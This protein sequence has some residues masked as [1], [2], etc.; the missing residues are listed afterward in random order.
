MKFTTLFSH[1]ALASL[2]TGCCT[3]GGSYMDI[4]GDAD[5]NTGVITLPV[6]LH[7]TEGQFHLV[8]SMGCSQFEWAKPETIAKVEVPLDFCKDAKLAP[9]G[10]PGRSVN[11]SFKFDIAGKNE[12]FSG[13]CM[14]FNNRKT[15]QINY[16]IHLNNRW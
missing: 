7:K 13:F 14:A 8:H 3:T 12:T 16:G 11:G 4:E 10:W 9:E 2:F 1:I 5:T 15:S 6:R